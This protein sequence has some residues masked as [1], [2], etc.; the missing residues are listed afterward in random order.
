[1]YIKS[2]HASLRQM[3]AFQTFSMCASAGVNFLVF[4][5]YQFLNRRNQSWGCR[6]T[7]SE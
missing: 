2:L 4:S 1:M 6:G 3:K 7:G 5:A